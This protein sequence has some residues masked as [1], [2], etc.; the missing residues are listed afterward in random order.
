MLLLEPLCNVSYLLATLLYD[1]YQVPSL[2]P[3]S[4]LVYTKIHLKLYCMFPTMFS[5]PDGLDYIG[6]SRLFTLSSDTPFGCEIID[7]PFDDLVEMEESFLAEI[8][9]PD[10]FVVPAATVVIAQ[11]M[12][13]STLNS[14]IYSLWVVY[15]GTA[16]QY[17]A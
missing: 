9:S 12:G 2:F 13:K 7:I 1:P 5:L 3:L 15:T 14:S 11:E 16:S 10:P 17:E 8:S 4:F 6:V